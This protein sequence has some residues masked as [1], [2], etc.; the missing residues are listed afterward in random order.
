MEIHDQI[1]RNEPET[2]L[3]QI[4]E[5]LKLNPKAMTKFSDYPSEISDKHKAMGQTVSNY[6]RKGKGLVDNA[7]QGIFPRYRD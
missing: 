2:K 3:W 6:L 7:Y 1:I 4:G 5:Q